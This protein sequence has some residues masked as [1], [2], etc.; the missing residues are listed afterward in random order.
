MCL[1]FKRDQEGKV[2]AFRGMSTSR[3]VL[4]VGDVSVCLKKK[5]TVF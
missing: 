2:K 5:D 1:G 4:K 3:P